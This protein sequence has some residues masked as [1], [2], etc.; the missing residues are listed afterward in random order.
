M[1]VSLWFELKFRMTKNRSASSPKALREE[2]KTEIASAMK[3]GLAKDIN[4]YLLS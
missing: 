3:D 1:P 4:Y 2:T